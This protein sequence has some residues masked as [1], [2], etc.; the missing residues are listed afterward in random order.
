MHNKYTVG[1]IWAEMLAS[2]SVDARICVNTLCVIALVR[3][4]AFSTIRQFEFDPCQ[5][6][7]NQWLQSI[8]VDTWCEE[9]QTL[10]I[11]YEKIRKCL[12]IWKGS[13]YILP[14]SPP[15]FCT[16]AKLSW[17]WKE[18]ENW[19]FRNWPLLSPALLKRSC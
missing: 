9:K 8:R 5:F 12:Q 7:S 11:N 18:K 19:I 13:K 6:S 1:I 4:I 10:L 2:I 17:K 14:A 16:P 3:S 15:G